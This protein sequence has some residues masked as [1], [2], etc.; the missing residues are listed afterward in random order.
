M[1][2]ARWL[3]CTD[4]TAML[5]FLHGKASDR[6]LRLF[7]VACCRHLQSS[8]PSPPEYDK[9]LEW[10]EL[11]ADGAASAEDLARIG[12][13]VT[14]Y[15]E[16]CA[17]DWWTGIARVI[18]CAVHLPR[19]DPLAIRQATLQVVRYDRLPGEDWAAEASEEFTY[20]AA[21][22]RELVGPF[23]FRPRWALASLS[24]NPAMLTPTVVD[25]AQGIYDRRAFDRLPLLAD[26]LEV[27]GCT[28]ADILA[29]CRQVKH[30][31]HHRLF[32]GRRLADDS[33]PGEHV[34]GCWV[35]DLLLGKE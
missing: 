24:V 10:A 30:R 23:L 25:L 29:H 35:V 7:A 12:D 18:A 20:Q 15:V 33:Q 27:A 11:F 28:S 8:W 13:E 6:K 17:P 3:A 19:A 26:A 9:F 21:L 34:R 22:L 5:A 2:G 32:R 16:D 14:G 31:G 4:P 1:T